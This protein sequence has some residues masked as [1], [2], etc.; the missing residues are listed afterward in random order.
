MQSTRKWEEYAYVDDVSSPNIS[1]TSHI[2]T[3]KHKQYLFFSLQTISKHYILVVV[4]I[5]FFQKRMQLGSKCILNPITTC[6]LGVN[7]LKEYRI[8]PP[9][10]YHLAP[11]YT[12]VTP[13]FPKCPAP[14]ETRAIVPWPVTSCA[15]ARGFTCLSPSQGNEA[16]SPLCQWWRRW[17]TLSSQPSGS[18]FE[19]SDGHWMTQSGFTGVDGRHHHVSDGQS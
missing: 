6:I 18:L 8:P 14:T 2:W 3:K 5:T 19:R 7:A 15:V 1:G 11:Y 10:S 12:W 13:L 4:D 9:G 16:T 17:G